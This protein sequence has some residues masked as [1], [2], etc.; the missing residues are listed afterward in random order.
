MGGRAVLRRWRVAVETAAL[1]VALVLV[2]IA[3]VAFDLEFINLSPLYTS[4]VAGGIFVIGLIVAG[5]LADYKEAE[6]V[7]AEM[8]AALEAILE[9]GRSIKET[10]PEFDLDR[11]KK[12]LVR[13]VDT[14]RDDLAGGTTTCLEAINEVSESFEELERLGAPPNYIVRLRQEQGVIR[15]S[16]LRVYHVQRT[17]FLPSAY[18]LIQTIVL[19]IIAGL[20][21]TRFDPVYEGLVVLVVISY[22]FLYL[23]RLLRIMDKPFRVTEQTMDDVSLFLLREFARRAAPQSRTKRP[24]P[25]G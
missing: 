13:V 19:L 9:D 14:F 24:S 5:T 12:V 20:E 25:K 3:L 22:F 18:V 1:V 16:A 21:V 23:L 8:A 6:K 7:P 17:D 2:K 10:T 11:L 15:K 4:I